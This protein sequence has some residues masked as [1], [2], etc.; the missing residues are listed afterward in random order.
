MRKL[1]VFNHVTLDGYFVNSS[2]DFGWARHGNDDPE[3]SA[4]V[5]ENAKGGGELVFGRKTY[6][7]MASYWPTAIAD[8]HAPVVAKQMNAVPKVV[9][10]KTLDKATWNNTRLLKGELKD[11]VQN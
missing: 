6:A 3:F 8:T 2:G 11:E 7:L 1:I 9:F 5:A 10:S 4:F